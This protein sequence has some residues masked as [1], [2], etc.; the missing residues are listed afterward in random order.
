MRRVRVRPEEREKDVAANEVTACSASQEH[1]Q[2][3]PFL[4]HIEELFATRAA[5]H[6]RDGTKCSKK[7]HDASGGWAPGRFT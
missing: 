3:E 2:G 7:R 1:Q 4:L 5:L 6:E